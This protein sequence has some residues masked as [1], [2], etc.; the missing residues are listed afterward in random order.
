MYKVITFVNCIQIIL[1]KKC[2]FHI[3]N[4]SVIKINTFYLFLKM[5]M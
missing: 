3:L 2:L 1:I 4:D 5:Y